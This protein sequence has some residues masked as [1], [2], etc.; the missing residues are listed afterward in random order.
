MDKPR[1]W[2]EAFDQLA[3]ENADLRDALMNII[4]LWELEAPLPEI[5]NAITRAATLIDSLPEVDV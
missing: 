4:G 5:E 2:E 3:D 1:N